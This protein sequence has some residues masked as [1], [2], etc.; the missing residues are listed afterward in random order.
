V[1]K[2]AAAHGVSVRAAAVDGGFVTAEQFDEL[3]SAEAVCRLGTPTPLTRG[4]G[5]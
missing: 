2:A 1:V 4:T 3:L 5:E